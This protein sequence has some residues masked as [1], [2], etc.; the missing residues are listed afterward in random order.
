[1]PPFQRYRYYNYRN[2]YR[3]WRRR[4]YFRRRFRTTFQR[5]RRRPR[6]RRRRFLYKPKRK[7]KRLRLVQ[8]QPTHIRK[9]K[10]KGILQLFGAG[11]GRYYNNFTLYKESFV[12]PQE[13]G[14]GGWSIQQMTLGNLYVQ[15]QYLMNW[16]TVSNKGLNLAR[17]TGAKI[18]LYRQPVVDY[19]FLYDI[20]PPYNVT[21]YYYNS[22]HPIK[23]LQ[24]KKKIIVPSFRTQPH[25]KKP[26]IRKKINPPKLLENKWYFQQNITN[27]PLI[28]FITMSCSL[29]NMFQATN[30]LNNNCSIH[31]LNTNFFQNATFSGIE[32]LPN[33]YTPKQGT[34]LYGLQQASVPWNTTP[35]SKVTYLGNPNI[36][37][38]GDMIGAMTKEEYGWAHWGN[39]F[40]HQYLDGTMPTFICSVPPSKMIEDHKSQ[41][42]A[43]ITGGA[44]FKHE[45]MV[46]ELRYNPNHDKGTGNVAFWVPNNIITSSKWEPT[47]NPDLQI[48]GFPLWILLWGWA[49]FTTHITSVP[50]LWQ[51]YTLCIRT[52]SLDQTYPNIVPLSTNYIHGLPPYTTD[53]HDITLSDHGH[54]YPKWRF[55]EEAING[56]LQTGPAA[57]KTENQQSISAHMKYHFYFKW[58]G[59]PSSMEKIYDP[60]AQPTYPIPTLQ[61]E[62]N[63][64]ISPATSIANYI[65]PWDIRHDIITKPAAERIKQCETYEDS[66]FTDGTTTTTSPN[67]NFQEAQK[68][69]TTKKKEQTLLLQLNN[70]KLL[71]RQLQ[72]RLRQLAQLNVEF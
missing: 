49:D 55:Q 44:T 35:I 2:R 31:T 29:T 13:P 8:F 43:Q 23:L 42:V 3:K 18:T 50:H 28:Q 67:Y 60:T 63:E 24:Y 30:S 59:N 19:I 40:W 54:W 9:C 17:Y 37:D 20:E 70:I 51:D 39:P 66:V 26:Y 65:Y 62:N 41:T 71:N 72:H 69:K 57:C 16:W 64:I 21:K 7:L 58:G 46:I 61:H 15:N 22:L 5:K 27:T 38:P 53:E 47:N 6:V 10:I 32:R 56:L 45:P 12:N 33:G 11:K 52:K 36:N 34:Y 1:M 48:E 68:K 25:N 4:P 14:G